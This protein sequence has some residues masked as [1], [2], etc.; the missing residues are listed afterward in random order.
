MKTTPF[1]KYTLNR[2]PQ[3]HFWKIVSVL[4]L[5]LWFLS[6][7]TSASQ[8]RELEVGPEP[9]VLKDSGILEN[10]RIFKVPSQGYIRSLVFSPKNR[11]IAT[12]GRNAKDINI[13][14]VESGKLLKQIPMRGKGEKRDRYGDVL[15]FHPSGEYLLVED[16]DVTN[17]GHF[18]V[19][20]VP[21][22][23]KEKTVVQERAGK[24][25]AFSA[26]GK[27][28][29]AEGGFR[30]SKSI[31]GDKKSIVLGLY[32]AKTFELMSRI[33][34]GYSSFVLSFTPDSNYL[35]DVAKLGKLNDKTDVTN[36]VSKEKLSIRI[37]SVPDLELVRVIEG[38]FNSITDE[39]LALTSDG[40]RIVLSGLIWDLN[41]KDENGKL[42]RELVTYEYDFKTGVLLKEYKVPISDVYLSKTEKYIMTEKS[43]ENALLIYDK[44]T[45]ELLEHVTV[46]ERLASANTF[47]SP[48]RTQVAIVQ[49][50]AF[51]VWDI[52]EK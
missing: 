40:K 20:S 8:Y 1:K 27:Y 18:V 2:L 12:S 45:E 52:V 9:K 43:I 49:K 42:I 32:D 34:E 4:S 26:D 28:F 10:R 36:P 33:E 29:A 31:G 37:W 50:G 14:D 22:F 44:D 17:P 38:V 35:V 13:Y 46:S 48:D 11:Y 41:A 30:F 3:L 51:Y 47:F 15:G 7:C 19:F 25:I 16:N 24:P 5:M 6:G 21:E 39:F 23:E